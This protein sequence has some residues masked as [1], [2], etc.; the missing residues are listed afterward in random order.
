MRRKKVCTNILQQYLN[1]TFMSAI[2]QRKMLVVLFVFKWLVIF[3]A[4]TCAI[5]TQTYHFLSQ[6]LTNSIFFILYLKKNNKP[7]ANGHNLFHSLVAS[8][9]YVL[10]PNVSSYVVIISIQHNYHF[11][12]FVST[13]RQKSQECIQC[14]HVLRTQ[15]CHETKNSPNTHFS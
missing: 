12:V 10:K 9:K 4:S 7:N 11:L 8:Q 14:K 6:Y 15:F 3:F 5:L 1:L 13:L 2:S